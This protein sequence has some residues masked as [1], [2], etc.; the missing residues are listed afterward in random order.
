MM[1]A[2]EVFFM[3]PI[4]R[5]KC[6]TYSFELKMQAVQLYYSG[7]SRTEIAEMLKVKNKR[8]INEWVNKIKDS[9]RNL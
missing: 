9:G 3:E 5:N 6:I 8:M 2:L 4:F 7:Y 1:S